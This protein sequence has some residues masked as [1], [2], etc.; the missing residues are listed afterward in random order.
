MDSA[1]KPPDPGSTIR[2]GAQSVSKRYGAVEANRSITF[3]VA[4][5]EIHAIVGENGAGKSTLMRLLQGLERPDSGTIIHDDVP[6]RLRDPQHALGLGIGMV[7]Q[8]FMLA[9]DLSL[10]ENFVLG[11]EPVGN[12]R[13]PLAI[14]NWK[15][16]RKQ[17]NALA[18]QANIEI[19]WDMRAGDAPVHVRQYVEIFRLLRR[20]MRALIL[21]EPT[22]VLAPQQVDQL[23]ALLRRLREDDTS[24]IF[25]SHKLNEV[26]ALADRVTVIRRGEVMASTGV[27]E[28]DIDTLTRHIVGEG[29][30]VPTAGR[31]AATPP[32]DQQPLLSVTD[33]S[34]PSLARSHP[35]FDIALDVRA[36]EIVGVAGVSGNG[37]EELFQCLAGLRTPSHGTITVGTQDLAGSDNAAFRRAGIGFIS[38]DRANEGLAKTASIADNVMAASQRDDRYRLGPFLNPIAMAHAARERLAKLSVRYGRVADM[39][40]SLSGG[41]QQRLVFAREIAAEPRLLIVSQPT[42][43]VDLG[44]VAAIHGIIGAFASEG[45]AVLLVSEELDE[46]ITLSH[47]ILVMAGGRV[48][49]EVE[50]TEATPEALG[51]LMLQSGPL[52]KEAA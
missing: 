52:R 39:A 35:L 17:G 49:G 28:T 33:L 34:A 51:R 6:V 11:D 48:V 25:I 18:E 27:D 40:K 10:L 15:S 47:R 29:G 50:A 3:G 24:I 5:D 8:D 7:H 41:N 46:L 16:A 42:R 30:A 21:D 1:P 43:G 9:P 38:P 12:G 13:N 37:Q 23:F 4:P 32:R 19:D 20:G 31:S 2:L 14:V 26:M 36:G 22:A 44:G 45:G